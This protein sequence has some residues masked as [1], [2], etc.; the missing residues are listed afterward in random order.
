VQRLSVLLGIL[1][2]LIAGCGNEKAP[3]AQEKKGDQPDESVL[4]I[5]PEQG[6]EI[7]NSEG[8]TKK[9]EI[10]DP[11][12]VRFE[13]EKS[14]VIISEISIKKSVDEIKDELISSAGKVTLLNEDDNSVSFQTDRKE[15][16]RSDVFVEQSDEENRVIIFMSPAAEY[17]KNKVKFDEFK[18]NIHF[19]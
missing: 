6:L 15:S 12:N 11:F 4:Y 16:I 19:N 17:E 1:V 7:T 3:E 9:E 8:W 18:E 5:N 14:T 2:I 13:N 10:S